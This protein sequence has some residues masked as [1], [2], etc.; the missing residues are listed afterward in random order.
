MWGQTFQIAD[1]SVVG[2]LIILEGLLSAD[3]ALVLAIMVRHLPTEQRQKA[4]MYGLIGAFAF[5]FIA[6]LFAAWIIQLWWLQMIGALY[7]LFITIKHFVAHYSDDD[8]PANKP[9]S[10]WQTVVAVEL[11]DMA[12]SIDSV[13]A[14]IAVV[15]GPSKMWVVFVGAI[16]G[17][18]LLRS[19]AGLFIKLLDRWPNINHLAYLLVGWVG[20]KLAFMAGEKFEETNK[21]I[22]LPFEIHEI[23]ETIFWGVMAA[24]VVLGM[25]WIL[26]RPAQPGEDGES[27]AAELWD[28]T[29]D[30]PKDSKTDP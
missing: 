23:P 29:V 24:I 20:V 9:M 21:S 28:E 27:E 5:R 10:F 11:A 25:A 13:V 16:L 26:T 22:K 6:I 30:G 4:L 14:A 7:L 19:A 8:S 15:R 18:I 1:L 12:F 3:N 17:I 2:F